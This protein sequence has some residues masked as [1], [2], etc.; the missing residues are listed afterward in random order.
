MMN[1]PNQSIHILKAYEG[2]GHA[3]CVITEHCR[4]VYNLWV[5]SNLPPLPFL[6]SRSLWISLCSVLGVLQNFEILHI[7]LS[8]RQSYENVP[9]FA[10]E[11]SARV[12]VVAYSNRAWV[13]RCEKCHSWKC[14]SLISPVGLYPGKNPWVF[15]PGG[16][17]CGGIG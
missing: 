11:T 2:I 3:Q 8:R 5:S 17:I 16:L 1:F 6:R 14:R 12:L 10:G 7:L 9:W 4:M 13:S 15:M